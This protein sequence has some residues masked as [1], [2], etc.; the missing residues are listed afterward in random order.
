MTSISTKPVVAL[1]LVGDVDRVGAIRVHD[2]DVAVLS[3]ITQASMEGHLGAI[4]RPNRRTVQV[5]SGRAGDVDWVRTVGVH[6]VDTAPTAVFCPRT[7]N[8]G[9]LGS[10]WRPGGIGDTHEFGQGVGEV[11]RVRTVRIHDV[12]VGLVLARGRPSVPAVG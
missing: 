9:Y 12:N 10:V 3:V 7:A 5:R 6:D 2:V 11:D 8:E 4:R 1:G